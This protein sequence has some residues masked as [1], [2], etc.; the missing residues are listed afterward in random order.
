MDVKVFKVLEDAGCAFFP[1]GGYIS[2]SDMKIQNYCVNEQNGSAICHYWTRTCF[3]HTQ[4]LAQANVWSAQNHNP[5]YIVWNQQI[6][7]PVYAAVR[8][9]MPVPNN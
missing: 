4:G 7:E 3:D 1:G 6:S 5:D 9:I 2:S 8:L